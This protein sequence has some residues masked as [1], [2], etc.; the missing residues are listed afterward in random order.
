MEKLVILALTCLS[1]STPAAFVICYHSAL[2]KKFDP[3]HSLGDNAILAAGAA[4]LG[5]ALKRNH[6]LKALR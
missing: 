4:A 5:K 6:T 3:L 2:T 1:L